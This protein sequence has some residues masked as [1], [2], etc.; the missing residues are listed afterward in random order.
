MYNLLI[1]YTYIPPYDYIELTPISCY[2]FSCEHTHCTLISEM[3]PSASF[4]V[5]VLRIS[6]PIPQISSWLA[7]P[8]PWASLIAQLVKNPL[9]I[10]ETPV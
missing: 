1:C 4:A 7:P 3:L 6:P 5:P 9:A 10:Q 2:T 8:I